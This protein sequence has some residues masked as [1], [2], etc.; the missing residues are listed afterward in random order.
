MYLT[1]SSIS[2]KSED[3]FT[4]IYK[5]LSKSLLKL[6]IIGTWKETSLE[7]SSFQP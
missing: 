7:N 1:K 3:Q 6:V 4:V 5:P 2:F